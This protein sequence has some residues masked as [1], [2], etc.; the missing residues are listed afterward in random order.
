[1]NQLAVNT[2]ASASSA[3]V[4]FNTAGELLSHVS[5]FA[6]QSVWSGATN[7]S[8]SDILAVQGSNDDVTYTTITS[9][10]LGSSSGS[11]LYNADGVWYKYVRVGY[12]RAAATAGTITINIS[13]KEYK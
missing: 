9:Q 3:S 8:V 2:M 12:T 10:A 13:L 11:W 1:M 5:G 4:S 6:I 7:A